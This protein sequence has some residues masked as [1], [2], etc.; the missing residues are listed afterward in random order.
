MNQSDNITNVVSKIMKVAREIGAIQKKQMNAQTGG[1]YGYFAI[2]SVMAA[3]S[4]AMDKAGLWIIPGCTDATTAEIS[5]VYHFTFM[6][7]DM[8]SGEYIERPWTQTN[9]IGVWVWNK[10][11]S[12]MTFKTA[13]DQT[14]GMIDS[15]AYKNFVL[16]LFGISTP[17][18]DTA[19][20]ERIAKEEKQRRYQEQRAERTIAPKVEPKPQPSPYSDAVAGDI[21]ANFS[22]EAEPAKEWTPTAQFITTRT[23][24]EKVL[25]WD[26]EKRRRIIGEFTAGR[27]NSMKDLTDPQLRDLHE[28]LKIEKRGLDASAVWDSEG[29]TALALSA[30]N[31]QKSNLWHLEGLEIEQAHTNLEHR[32]KKA[33]AT[34]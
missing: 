26:D 27:T 1:N 14:S 6:I 34:I 7:V 30:T 13:K 16:K 9:A 8:E 19:E 18:A 10:E 23:Y 31:K 20:A 2:E 11:A 28:L 22:D 24:I 33:S 15:Y 25:K 4:D 3:V 5:A 12:A 29:R 17:D 32:I 21:D